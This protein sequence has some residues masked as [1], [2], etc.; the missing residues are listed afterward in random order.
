MRVK[1]GSIGSRSFDPHAVDGTKR[2]FV[3]SEAVVPLLD[4]YHKKGDDVR[5]SRST[6]KWLETRIDNQND[7][8][9]DTI[10]EEDF[11]ARVSRFACKS[12]S[13]I[14]IAVVL[15]TVGE[16][17]YNSLNGHPVSQNNPFMDAVFT[18][19]LPFAVAFAFY[20]L[21]GMFERHTAFLLNLHLETPAV[22]AHL[23]AYNRIVRG[24]KNDG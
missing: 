21:T 20:K 8:M 12:S 5:L 16:S 1:I 24:D 3:V 11:A 6:L 19:A 15:Y 13:V 4:C 14:V 17:V 7:G 18:N 23:N 22:S 9:A 10:R 2:K